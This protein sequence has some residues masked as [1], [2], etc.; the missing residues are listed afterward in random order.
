MKL[1]NEKWTIK[2]LKL[3]TVIAQALYIH[4]TD[5]EKKRKYLYG[6]IYATHSHKSAQ[7][8]STHCYLQITRTMPAFPS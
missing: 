1:N 2:L 5:N 6:A 7:T 8:W 4:E 3:T